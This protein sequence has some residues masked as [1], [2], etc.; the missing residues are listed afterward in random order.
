MKEYGIFRGGSGECSEKEMKL[1]GGANNKKNEAFFFFFFFFRERGEKRKNFARLSAC[2]LGKTFF[3][4]LSFLQPLALSLL[5]F[6]SDPPRDYI[7]RA[8]SARYCIE[9][10]LGH[11]GKIRKKRGIKK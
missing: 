2:F 11:T 8:E 10:V 6:L 4:L 5:H 9:L 1:L 7:L 3:F